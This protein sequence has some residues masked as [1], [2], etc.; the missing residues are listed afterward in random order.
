MEGASDERFWNK[1]I[2]TNKV[3]VQ[4]CH[5]CKSLNSIVDEHI[6]QGVMNFIAVTDSDFNVILGTIPN[7]P[8]LF[9]T[10]DHDVE[11]MMYHSNRSFKELVNA[12]DRGNKIG[13][14]VENGHDLLNETIQITND[15][16]YCKLSAIKNGFDLEFSNEDEKTHEIERPKYE[17]ALDGKTGQYLGLDKV[18]CKVHGFTC[19]CG[20]KPPKV[21]D[22]IEKT[23]NEKANQYDSWHLSNGHDISYILPFL[24]RRRCKHRNKQMNHEFID[25]VLYAAYKFDD[26]KQ[27]KLYAAM[28]R[29]SIQNNIKIFA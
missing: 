13:D 15:I 27:T 5:G 29:W 9:I 12:I 19:S 25:S 1:F 14:Y 16:G 21:Q 8:N 22:I 4:I 11:M 2:D 23:T 24:I 20:K 3:R 17:D 18:V 7:K 26:F 6:N 28:K 10:D